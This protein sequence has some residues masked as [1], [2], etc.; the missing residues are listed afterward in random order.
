MAHPDMQH[1]VGG[2]GTTIGGFED[3][4]DAGE[5]VA[6]EAGASIRERDALEALS[7]PWMRLPWQARRR[8]SSDDMVGGVRRV[9]AW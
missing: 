7:R 9:L 4:E 8:G 6:F 5:A 3:D 2:S 1:C